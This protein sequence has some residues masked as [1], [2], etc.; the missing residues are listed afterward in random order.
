M[1]KNVMDITASFEKF[2]LDVEFIQNI[3]EFMKPVKFDAD[4]LGF[5]AI[6]FIPAGDHFFGAEHTMARYET[7]FYKPML[8]NWH[9][10]ESWEVAGAKDALER[11]TE[12][13]IPF[14]FAVDQ[15]PTKLR[16]PLQFIGRIK[17]DLPRIFLT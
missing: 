2:I 9:N 12:L 11:A 17:I 4:E 8:S 6:Q 13:W 5:D 10:Y 3:I 1:D 14:L 16:Q 7:A 15:M